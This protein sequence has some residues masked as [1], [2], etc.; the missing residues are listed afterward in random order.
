[1]GITKFYKNKMEV[2]KK[3]LTN[4]LNSICTQKEI[5]KHLQ[6]CLVRYLRV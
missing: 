6:K 4:M 2:M 1:M 5:L 3:G